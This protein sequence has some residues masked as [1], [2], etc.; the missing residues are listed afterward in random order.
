MTKTW[1][2][3]EREVD[4]LLEAET[5]RRRAALR[6]ELAAKER[7]RAAMAHLDKFNAHHVIEDPPTPEEV[8][9]RHRWGD[10]ALARD[11]EKVDANE[12]RFA[13]EEAERMKSLNRLPRMRTGPEGFERKRFV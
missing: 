12:R 9:Q 3:L 2:E 7:H 5:K 11:Q 4:A 1:E 6:E 13:A 8:A 10:E